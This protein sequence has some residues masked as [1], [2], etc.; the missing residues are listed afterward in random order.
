MEFEDDFIEDSDASQCS[1]E[2]ES[3]EPFFLT[4]TQSEIPTLPPLPPPKP[5][6][7]VLP[8]TS[9]ARTLI[10]SVSSLITFGNSSIGTSVPGT[11]YDLAPQLSHVRERFPRFIADV[12]KTQNTPEFKLLNRYDELRRRFTNAHS[13][14]SKL[15][16]LIHLHGRTLRD[17]EGND[18]PCESLKAEL[19]ATSILLRNSITKLQ[20]SHAVVQDLQDENERLRADIS[21]QLK[22]LNRGCRGVFGPIRKE[23]A[24]LEIGLSCGARERADSIARAESGVLAVEQGVQGLKTQ[25]ANVESRIAVLKK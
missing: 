12:H 18:D 21:V 8:M 25:I 7:S 22:A 24:K 15:K 3:T 20:Q 1:E 10:S 4:A 19:H 17:L 23:I 11:I 14:N 13:L 2:E 16:H 6:A 9:L 5:I